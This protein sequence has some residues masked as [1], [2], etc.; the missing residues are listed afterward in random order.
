MPWI[1]ALL[2]SLSPAA[3]GE[4]TVDLSLTNADVEALAGQ[5]GMI[6]LKLTPSAASRLQ[7]MTAQSY[8]KRLEVKLEGVPILQTQIYTTIESGVIQIDNSPPAV[9]RRLFQELRPKGN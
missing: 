2:P 4:E 3:P 9:S 1:L 8:G 6:W 7:T 5:D